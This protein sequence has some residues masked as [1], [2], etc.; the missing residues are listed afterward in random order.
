MENPDRQ[1]K[2]ERKR[3]KLNAEERRVG[4]RQICERERE[5]GVRGTTIPLNAE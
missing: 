4:Q 3:R 1:K 5:R 2:K